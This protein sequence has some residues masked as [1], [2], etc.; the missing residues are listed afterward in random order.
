MKLHYTFGE[1]ASER[2]QVSDSCSWQSIKY[3]SKRSKCARWS[4]NMTL[5][6]VRTFTGRGARVG[7]ESSSA[8]LCQQMVTFGSLCHAIEEENLSPSFKN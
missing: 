1:L 5:S 6:S 3:Q 2:I 4:D 7:G 8:H